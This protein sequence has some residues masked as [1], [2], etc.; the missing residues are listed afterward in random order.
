MVTQTDQRRR[1]GLEKK[2]CISLIPSITDLPFYIFCYFQIQ[3]K[4]QNLFF[5]KFE[6]K[7]QTF[8]Y[9]FFFKFKI[10]E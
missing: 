3:T 4:L 10:K 9:G 6:M 2:T 1:E 8:F 5:L 7:L